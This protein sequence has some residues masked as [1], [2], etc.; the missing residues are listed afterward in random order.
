MKKAIMCLAAM[1]AFLLPGNAQNY[2]VETNVADYAGFGTMN[3][4]ASAAI[5][6]RWSIHA[7]IKYNPFLFK[8][9]TPDPLSARQQLYRAGVRYW[10]WNVYSGWWLSGS[11]QYQEYNRGG[12]VSPETREGDRYGAGLSAGYSYMLHPHLNLDLGLGFWGGYDRYTVYACPVCGLTTDSGEKM[13]FLPNDVI[14]G[15]VYVF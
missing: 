2:S 4:T 11:L 5:A 14:L 3:L 13:F 9:E 1:L 7:G 6:R 8:A 12:I 15:L 10:P